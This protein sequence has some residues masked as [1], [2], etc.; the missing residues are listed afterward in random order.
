MP[1]S[2]TTLNEVAE[3]VFISTRL[4]LTLPVISASDEREV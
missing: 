4:P 2:V 1:R 3:I